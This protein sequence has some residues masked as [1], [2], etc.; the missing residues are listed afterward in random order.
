M[1]PMYL[2]TISFYFTKST[3]LFCTL[4]TRGLPFMNLIFVMYPHDVANSHCSMTSD[5]QP[6]SNALK[7]ASDH[8]CS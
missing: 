8:R 1:Y 2:V 4:V 7:Y 6:R 3:E 5:R